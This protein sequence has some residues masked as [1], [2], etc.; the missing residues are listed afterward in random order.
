M[1]KKGTNST[2]F[3]DGMVGA[4]MDGDSMVVDFMLVIV[5]S[6]VG[7]L[8]TLTSESVILHQLVTSQ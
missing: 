7:D 4:N 1:A 5:D 3:A 8:Q 6:A 2:V